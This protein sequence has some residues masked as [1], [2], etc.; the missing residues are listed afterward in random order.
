[1]LCKKQIEMEILELI[2]RPLLATLRFLY[3]LLELGVI[4][5]PFYWVGWMTLRVISF[6]KIPSYGINEPDEETL[7]VCM[8][9]WFIGYL[10]FVIILVKMLSW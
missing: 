9:T 6:K 1:M 8:F 10:S 3:S 2:F 4:T 5:R 7:T